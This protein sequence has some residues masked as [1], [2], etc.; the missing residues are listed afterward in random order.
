MNNLSLDNLKYGAEVGDL[1]VDAVRAVCREL[2][3]LREEQTELISKLRFAHD[4]LIEINPYNYTH[5]D[6]CEINAA[7]VEVILGLAPALGENHGKTEQWWA[8]REDHSKP[9]AIVELSD[10]ISAA[11]A[12]GQVPRRKAVNELYD[13]AL[14]VGHRLYAAP[15]L[16]AVPEYPEFL[17]CPVLLEPGL[18]LGTGIKTSTLLEAL[19]RRA[20]YYS[21]LEAMTPEEREE[22]DSSTAAFKALLDGAI[23]AAPKP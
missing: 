4:T 16:P 14:V 19:A 23:T 7:S 10:Y 1:G 11:E 21:R 8:L 13:G 15:Q 20:E 2:L 6:V 5:D 12:L 18:R 9:V 17:P 3:A 22:H